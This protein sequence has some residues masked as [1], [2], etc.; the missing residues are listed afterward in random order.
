MLTT[1]SGGVRTP[2]RVLDFATSVHTVKP[3]Y[4]GH[5]RDLRNTGTLKILTGRRGLMS[6]LMACHTKT[7]HARKHTGRDGDIGDI[8]KAL[9]ILNS[10][11]INLQ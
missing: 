8:W 2:I 5:P 7:L 4:N 1:R 10:R 6:I 11:C 9:T 3:V